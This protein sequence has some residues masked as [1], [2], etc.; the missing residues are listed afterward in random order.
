MKTSQANSLVTARRWSEIVPGFF[1]ILWIAGSGV[2]P[3]HADR[4]TL[5]PTRTQVALRLPVPPIIDGVINRAEWEQAGGNNDYWQVTPDT[6]S[7]VSDGIRGGVV[8]DV[9]TLPDDADD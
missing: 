8:G 2:L 7:W 9:S 5:D 1:A 4:T 3:V 6:S